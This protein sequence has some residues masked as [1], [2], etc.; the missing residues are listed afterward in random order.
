MSVES[1]KAP[2]RYRKRRR[3]E[4][5]AQTRERIAEA[6]VNLHGTVGPAGATVSAIAREAGVQRATVYRHFA[7]E[8]ELFDACT[9]RFYGRFPMPDPAR[10]A[11][12]ADP[13][14]RLRRALGELYAWFEKTQAMLS[15]VQRD[16]EHVPPRTREAFLGY[17]AEAK[18]ILIRG[19]PERGGARER[20]AAAVGHAIAF[21][22]WRSLTA[23]QGLD[24]V[25]AVGLM[26][27]MVAGAGASNRPP[28]G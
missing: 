15:N 13:D 19:R 22:T 25:E 2:R 11:E 9:A 6:T 3:A 20:V 23:E 14:L 16:R 24:S 5:E 28:S 27:R 21:S 17:F 4:L 1:T 26:S 10:W 7:D 12:I 8:Q 18:A